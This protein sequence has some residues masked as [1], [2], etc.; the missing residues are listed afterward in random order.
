M[1]RSLMQYTCKS[2]G[3]QLSIASTVKPVLSSHSKMDKTKV[4]KTKGSLMK[5]EST[6]E[7]SLGAFC[8]TFD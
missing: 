7:C 8:N 3:K 6:A 2:K 1:G 4:F 5:V